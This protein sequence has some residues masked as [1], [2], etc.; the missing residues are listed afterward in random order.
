M[1]AS[2]DAHCSGSDET[3]ELAPVPLWL[4]DYSALK[5]L[6]DD[7]RQDG[8]RDLRAYLRDDI[9]RA[10]ECAEQIKVLKVNRAALAVFEARDCDELVG[11]LSRVFRDDMLTSLT[12]EVARNRSPICVAA[13]KQY[14]T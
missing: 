8:V 12:E 1:T 11:N 4:E 7:W 13:E 10:K 5:A 6:L 9:S 2:H 3:F 14:R